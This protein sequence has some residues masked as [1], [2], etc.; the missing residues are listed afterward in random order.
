[1]KTWRTGTVAVL[2]LCAVC[3]CSNH[4]SGGSSG[5]SD[6]GAVAQDD[7]GT[8]GASDSGTAL[9]GDDAG[10]ALPGDDAGTAA[11]A[12]AAP[13]GGTIGA[14]DAGTDGGTSIADCE[15]I[16]PADLGASVTAQVTLRPP[17][18]G[19][20]TC[21]DATS[22][23]SGNVAAGLTINNPGEPAFGSWQIFNPAGAPQ[24]STPPI[25]GDLFPE[26]PGF[27]GAVLDTSAS[28]PVDRFTLIQPDA[29]RRDGQ[30]VGGN[31]AVDRTFRSWPN[32]L[33]VVTT[34]CDIAGGLVEIRHFG[35]DGSLLFHGSNGGLG[36]PRTVAG[37]GTPGG[38][39]LVIFST[40]QAS[41]TTGIP[42]M[43]EF[44]V[45]FDATG[46]VFAG[47]FVVAPQPTPEDIIVRTLVDG[48]VAVRSGGHWLG[49]LPANGGTTLQP[50]PSWLADGH[51]LTI[52]RNERAYALLPS[53]GLNHLDLVSIGGNVCGTVT[54]PG[55][56]G[57]TTGA[58]GT[59]IGA[60]GTNGCTKTWWSGLL[61]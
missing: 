25:D 36:C 53:G 43:T 29:S 20:F 61:K 33:L 47:P 54:F 30:V 22:D 42:P 49:V 31:G 24:G 48:S 56:Q 46:K 15:G 27:E 11:D 41:Q 32:G 35:A 37:A 50:P 3:A 10:T 12:G 1:L 52:V 4:S 14:A 39:S 6:A 18:R 23:E 38:L 55:V 8:Q 2:A 59:V 60:S 7:G 17:F 9:P 34:S 40:G 51:D 58:D 19:D 16:V 13:D 57:V 26:G 45:W 21:S 28:P 44:G 5:S